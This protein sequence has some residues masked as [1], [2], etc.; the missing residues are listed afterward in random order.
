MYQRSQELAHFQSIL[1]IAE[2]KDPKHFDLLIELGHAAINNR[3]P[4]YIANEILKI[5]RAD[6]IILQFPTYW[7]G[8]P[9]ILKGWL[10]L[11]FVNQIAYDVDKRQWLDDGLFKVC[12]I[13]LII[14]RR[15]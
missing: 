5:Q 9:A 4:D 3:L 7:F 8:F 11:C 13:S 6:L 1:F 14:Y 10:D 2:R 15:S 12:T